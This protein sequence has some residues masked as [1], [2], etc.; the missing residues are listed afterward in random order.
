MKASEFKKIIR[1]EV[2]KETNQQ[3]LN[4]DMALVGDIALGVAGGLAGLWALV[5]GVPLVVGALGSVAGD[6]ADRMEAKAKEAAAKA[7]REGRLETIK[8]IVAKFQNDTKLADMYQALPPY[9]KT[10]GST[11]AQQSNKL[12]TKQLQDI[13]KYIKAKL[14]PEEM[15]YFED[16]SAMLRTG[17]IKETSALSEAPMAAPTS[18]DYNNP[19]DEWKDILTKAMQRFS[20]FPKNPKVV[21]DTAN[22]IMAVYK[23]G[24]KKVGMNMKPTELQDFANSLIKYD[25]DKVMKG[26]VDGLIAYIK[27]DLDPNG[28]PNWANPSVKKELKAGKWS[29]ITPQTK[30]KVG[31]EIVKMGNIWFGTI[32]KIK[33]D[34]YYIRYDADYA[35][36]KPTKAS[37]R[38]LEGL[39]ALMRKK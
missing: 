23:L 2:R 5:K 9:D 36:D 7:K 31:D 6:L 24:G 15:A 34:N 3:R 25:D 32:V 22:L 11:Q 19:G 21:K 37:R 17:D 33:G 10:F 4:E 26:P 30:L 14:T 28:V 27:N 12:R 18:Y 38:A 1:E 16:V 13:A 29:R 35:E 20:K 8:P 39:F